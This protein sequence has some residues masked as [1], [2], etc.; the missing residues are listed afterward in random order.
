MFL[1]ASFDSM[2]SSIVVN[3][4]TRLK[5]GGRFTKLR[6]EFLRVRSINESLGVISNH[7]YNLW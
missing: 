5:V 1:V 2:A 6:V 3:A 7:K 4:D